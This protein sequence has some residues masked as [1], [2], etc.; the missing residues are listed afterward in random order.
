MLVVKKIYM[1]NFSLI[2]KLF[3]VVTKNY[4]KLL[5]FLPLSLLS[6][7]VPFNSVIRSSIDSFKT[8]FHISAKKVVLLK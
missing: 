1:E 8:V 7:F 2:L 3:K 6:N 5:S 4:L